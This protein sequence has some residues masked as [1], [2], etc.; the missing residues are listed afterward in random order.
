MMLMRYSRLPGETIGT[1]VPQT[2]F[3]GVNVLK[4]FYRILTG[5]T[6]LMFFHD[7]LWTRVKNS[8]AFVQIKIFHWACIQ[9]VI[10]IKQREASE[11]TTSRT[12]HNINRSNQTYCYFTYI[13]ISRIN[14][15]T[16]FCI[17]KRRS[18]RFSS[19]F[20][21]DAIIRNI[22]TFERQ[23]PSSLHQAFLVASRHHESS[24]QRQQQHCEQ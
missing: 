2:A 22:N 1:Q 17:E 10:N 8:S 9:E 20:F 7:F 12:N 3:N 6:C 21:F 23:R 16:S 18:F 11:H 24:A 19:T 14:G 13:T 5:P 4:L 15:E